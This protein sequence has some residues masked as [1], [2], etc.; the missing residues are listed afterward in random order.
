MG[1]LMSERAFWL[2]LLAIVGSYF[3][4][5]GVVDHLLPDPARCVDQST[6]WSY[7]AEDRER[8]IRACATWGR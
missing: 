1:D 5:D 6:S 2:G 7:T 4:L 3:I 8:I